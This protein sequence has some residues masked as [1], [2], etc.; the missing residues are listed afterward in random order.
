MKLAAA[1]EKVDARLVLRNRG[2]SEPG[3]GALGCP[4]Y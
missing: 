2:W 4:S 3:A 1:D